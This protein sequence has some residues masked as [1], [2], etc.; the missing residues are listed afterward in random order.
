MNVISLC[1]V[2]EVLW[3]L[4]DRYIFCYLRHLPLL[5]HMQSQVNWFDGSRYSCVLI[6]SFVAIAEWGGA[7][8]SNRCWKAGI[9]QRSRQALQGDPWKADAW[10]H[11]PQE[12]PGSDRPCRRCWLCAISWHGPP[13]WVGEAPG[14]GLV[15][16]IFLNIPVQMSIKVIQAIK[17]GWLA[18]Q[19]RELRVR[20]HNKR[21]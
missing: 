4:N 13:G 1:E 7:R 8:V 3:C 16:H 2:L 15:A 10:C 5:N 12:Q 6:C 11:L 18:Q 17:R 20:R 9:N 14:H 19:W 21:G